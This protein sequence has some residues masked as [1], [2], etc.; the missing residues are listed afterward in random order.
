MESYDGWKVDKKN[1][2]ACSKMKKYIFD[3][4]NG[5]YMGKDGTTKIMKKGKNGGLKGRYKT[6]I[7]LSNKYSKV[8]TGIKWL[9]RGFVA[10]SIAN[11]ELQA[12]NHKI[13]NS[14]RITNDAIDAVSLLP[15]CWHVSFFYEL[16]K[17]YGPSTWF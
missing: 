12:L 13:S 17:K 16:G 6:Q 3:Y 11:T 2:A 4:K 10:V 15:Y 8:A 14:E 9:G 5:T 1:D 7:E